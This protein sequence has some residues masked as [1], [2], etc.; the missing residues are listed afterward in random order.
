M[1]HTGARWMASTGELVVWNSNQMEISETQTHFL[2]ILTSFWRH[3][4]DTTFFS[5]HTLVDNI[6][7]LVN[8][9][10]RFSWTRLRTKNCTPSETQNEKPSL[11]KLFVEISG[12][13]EMSSAISL[14][15]RLS[16]VND[17]VIFNLSRGKSVCIL[18]L[19]V[20]TWESSFVP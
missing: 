10:S 15:E 19:C 6:L 7:D 12:V 13:S 1:W 20:V 11:K 16:L 8:E 14:W 4:K 17:E 3:Q 5:S 9:C 18:R 2:R